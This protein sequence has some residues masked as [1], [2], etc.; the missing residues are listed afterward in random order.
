MKLKGDC[1]LHI[2]LWNIGWT[3]VLINIDNIDYFLLNLVYFEN[4][5]W[6]GLVDFLRSLGS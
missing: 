2:D 6:A 1:T 3:N 4:A 5:N